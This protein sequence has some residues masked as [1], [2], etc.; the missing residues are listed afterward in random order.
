MDAAR[1]PASLSTFENREIV[2][3]LVRSLANAALLLLGV[4]GLCAGTLWVAH[5]FR[6]V[7]PLIVVSGSM[8]PQINTG[9]LIFA[10]P[11]HVEDLKAGDIAS[12]VGLQK[13]EYVTHRVTSVD[14]SDDSVIVQMKGDANAVEDPY[15][16][17]YERGDIAW[18]PALTVSGGGYVAAYLLRPQVLVPAMVG[19]FA[20]L[21]LGLFPSESQPSKATTRKMPPA[22]HHKKATA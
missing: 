2:M 19:I 8:S 18:T 12:L 20:L 3:R 13:Q 4:V 9:D 7:Q 22:G 14:V 17:V 10:L 21:L 16:Y 5:Y 1:C 6:L 15:P 11:K